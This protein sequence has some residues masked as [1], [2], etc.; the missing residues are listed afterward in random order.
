VSAFLEPAL[1]DMLAAAMRRMEREYPGGPGL[2]GV[3][4][5]EAGEGPLIEFWCFRSQVGA[6]T[7][8]AWTCSRDLT[9]HAEEVLR[10]LVYRGWARDVQTVSGEVASLRLTETGLAQLAERALLRGGES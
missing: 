3:P 7:A 2:H 4:F 5:A 8:G 9:T 6:L 10:D 1:R